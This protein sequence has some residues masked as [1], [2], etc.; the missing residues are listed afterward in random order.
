MDQM[1]KMRKMGGGFEDNKPPPIEGQQPIKQDD[2]FDNETS[3]TATP[4]TRKRKG[5]R[6]RKS[7]KKGKSRK[8]RRHRKYR[9]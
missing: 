5:G 2:P 1:Y 4:A 8:S 7:S 9:R 3:M 6:R